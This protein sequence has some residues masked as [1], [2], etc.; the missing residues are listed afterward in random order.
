MTKAEER[1]E[2]YAK[3]CLIWRAGL[4]QRLNDSKGIAAAKA[5]AKAG[6]QK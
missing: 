6:K 3:V 2:N 4:K 5:A 1:H